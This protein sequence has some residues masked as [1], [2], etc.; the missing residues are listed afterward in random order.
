MNA[1]AQPFRSLPSVDQ[2]KA[3]PAWDGVVVTD[4]ISTRICREIIAAARTAIAAGELQSAAQVSGAIDNQLASALSVLMGP[5]LRPVY[6]GMGVLVHT[7]AGRAPLS[8]DALAHITET[9]A[10]YCN[11]EMSLTTGQRGSRQDL[12]KPLIRWLFTAEDALVVNNGAAAIM[13]A[14]HALA[15]DRPVLVSRGELV[16]IGGSFRVPDVMTAAGASLTEVGT[17]NRTWARDYDVALTDLAAA[18]RPAAALLQVHRSNFSIDGFV[19]T[20]TVT[21]LATLAHAHDLPLIVDLGSGVVGDLSRWQLLAEPTVQQTL[22]AGADLVTFSG[23][24]LLGGPQAGLIVGK[25]RWLA[26]LATSAMARAV[27]VDSMTLAGLETTLRSHVQGRATVA[28]P[29]W[30]AIDLDADELHVRAQTLAAQLEGGLDDSWQVGIGTA[31]ATIGGG[32]QPGSTLQSTAL[33]LRR[34]GWSAEALVTALRRGQPAVIGR[35]RGAE[36]LLDLRSLFAGAAARVPQAD[37]SAIA[38]AQPTSTGA[39]TSTIAVIMNKLETELEV[40]FSA[41]PRL[42]RLGN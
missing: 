26:R 33:T 25:R 39:S 31:E 13:L 12:L 36:V 28:L 23:D 41:L 29:L 4:E 6:N 1:P 38:G 20:P 15:R 14:L 2:L 19:H 5:A 35:P 18:G 40:A 17:T 10:G 21:E 34:Q 22:Q 3:R 42:P 9:S 30:Q 7:N 32:A 27:R 11:L 37:Q 24:K 16:E 8:P